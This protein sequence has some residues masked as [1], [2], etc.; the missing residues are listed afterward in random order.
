MKEERTFYLPYLI[1]SFM[2][3]AT[4]PTARRGLA[5]LIDQAAVSGTNFITSIIIARTLIKE[6]FGLY[7][8]GFS[9][10]IFLVNIQNS[11]IYFPYTILSPKLKEKE[12][13]LYTGSMLIHQIGF[14]FL[15]VLGLVIAGV[16][17]S[18]GIGPRGLNNILFILAA[19]T[20]FIL[21]RN[22]AR[23][24]SLARLKPKNALLI[25]LAV[26]IIQIP[27]I[28][29]LMSSG[30]LS[31]ARAYWIVG[32]AC[33]IPSAIWIFL[34]RSEFKPKIQ[35]SKLD[36]KK[37][38]AIVKWLFARDIV[39]L[40]NFQ[41]YPW[42]LTAFKGVAEVGILAAAVGV[43]NFANPLMFGIGNFLV[44]HSAHKYALKG[45]RELKHMVAKATYILGIIMGLFCL[46]MIIYGDRIVLMFFGRQY[47]G[48][49]TLVGLLALSQFVYSITNPTEAGLLAIKRADLEFK[50]YFYVL[51]F[52]LTLGLWL[53]HSFGTIGV[54]ISSLASSV[55]ISMYR[56]TVFN[57]QIKLLSASL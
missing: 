53:I 25:D 5:T 56:F 36:L 3:Q 49:G 1:S 24:I 35:N 18:L 10:L 29:L 39:A 40:L 46:A 4:G 30:A 31:A 41:I 17:T 11:L 48:T 44:P 42:V 14:S 28:F 34:K 50:S 2:K 15:S 19:V 38:W 6:E 57:R 54:G 45:A 51:I 21:F 33:C 26:L 20:L 12:I 43:L 47:S 52:N 16:I 9:V 22:F 23:R 55:F 32:L 13:S 27:G 8:L 7:S 37:N